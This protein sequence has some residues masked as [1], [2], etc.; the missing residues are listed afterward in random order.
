MMRA[1]LGAMPL[2]KILMCEGCTDWR[3]EADY[4]QSEEDGRHGVCLW[5]GSNRA[6]DEQVRARQCALI[7]PY[8]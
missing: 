3:A 6:S 7:L 5:C 1:D 2:G 4:T 8:Y